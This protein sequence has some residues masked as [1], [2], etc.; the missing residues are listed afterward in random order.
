MKYVDEYRDPQLAKRIAA[1]GVAGQLRSIDGDD[2]CAFRRGARFAHAAN[3]FSIR[4]GQRRGTAIAADARSAH[5]V[6][7]RLHQRE[8]ARGVEAF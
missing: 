3:D 1:E 2:G 5:H 7:A 4:S 6:D 8:I